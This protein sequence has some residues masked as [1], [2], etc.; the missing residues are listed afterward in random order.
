MVIAPPS[1][2]VSLVSDAGDRESVVF[3]PMQMTAF[4]STAVCVN[5]VFKLPVDCT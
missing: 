3:F 1:T 5:S 2:V 4:F